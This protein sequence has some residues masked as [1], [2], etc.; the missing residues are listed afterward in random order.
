MAY[1]L[2]KRSPWW[3]LKRAGELGGLL[4]GGSALGRWIVDLLLHIADNPPPGVGQ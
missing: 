3:W 2:T 4:W 1:P